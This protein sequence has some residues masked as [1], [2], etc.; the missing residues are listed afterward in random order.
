MPKIYEVEVYP[1]PKTYVIKAENLAQAKELASEKF[2]GENDGKSIY[3]IKVTDIPTEE[4]K[5]EE[6]EEREKMERNEM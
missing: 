4:E 1:Y 6:E 3:E 2:Y 5:I